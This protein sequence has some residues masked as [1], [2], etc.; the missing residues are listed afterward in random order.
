MLD[1]PDHILWWI[2]LD[3]FE[4]GGLST[5]INPI[6]T[7]IY[8]NWIYINL[9]FIKWFKPWSNIQSKNPIWPI[10]LPLNPMYGLIH[11]LGLDLNPTLDHGSWSK[12]MHG[13]IHDSGLW[14]L[15]HACTHDLNACMH[16]CVI[17][18][19][20][21]NPTCNMHAWVD[22]WSGSWSGSNSG[23][24]MWILSPATPHDPTWIQF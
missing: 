7:P 3:H 19:I 1:P 16:T 21:L 5:G 17:H 23:S 20:G 10:T 22:P 12:C 24:W 2:I 9:Y 4:G 15:M 18:N 11:D 14:I 13:L 8:I 6:Q